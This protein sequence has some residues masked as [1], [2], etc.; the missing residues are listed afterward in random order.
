M[1]GEWGQ[2]PLR[3]YNGIVCGS[4]TFGRIFPRAVAPTSARRPPQNGVMGAPGA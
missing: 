3:L 2:I 4:M 1:I